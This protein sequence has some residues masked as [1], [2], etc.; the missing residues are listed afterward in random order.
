MSKIE[1]LVVLMLENRSF[2]NIFGNLYPK[3]EAFDGLD[4]SEFESLA[5][6]GRIGRTDRR[7]ER[8]RRAAGNRAHARSRP[9]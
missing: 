3:S 9:G 4:G 1:H 8:Y 7:L 5:Q 2:D 6:A